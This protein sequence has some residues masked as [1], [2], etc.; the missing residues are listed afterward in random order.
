MPVCLASEALIFP[1]LLPH[2]R[3]QLSDKECFSMKAHQST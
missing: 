1:L 3:V 2:Q